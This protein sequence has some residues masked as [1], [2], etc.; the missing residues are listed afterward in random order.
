M[1]D[2]KTPSVDAAYALETP[3]DN[4][5]LYKSWAKTY[6]DDFVDRT[7]Y[8]QFK[9]ISDAV[10]AQR[11]RLKGPVLDVGCGTGVVGI[12]LRDAGIN[13]IDGIDISQEMLDV[14]ATKTSANG[15]SAY[16]NLIQ[17]D[18]TQTIDIADNRY[19]A[20]LSAGTFTHGHLGPEALNELWRV[21][22][23][24]AM[25]SI[26]VRSTH[27][28]SDGFAAKLDQDAMDDVI[29]DLELTEINVYADDA[30]NH[31]HAAD[32]AMMVVCRVT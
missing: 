18:L 25:I 12:Y 21:A 30:P 14:A 10:L 28:E 7:H 1:S 2:S 26:A 24:G 29:R 20:I 11:D 31:S 8:Q 22:A 13:D 3:E 17:A 4:V 9:T 32:T 19:G 5:A 15:D 6:D 23:P 16:R 27:Y